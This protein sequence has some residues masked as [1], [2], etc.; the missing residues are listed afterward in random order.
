MNLFEL[1]RKKAPDIVLLAAKHGALNIRLFGSVARKQSDD[2][3]D[4]DF[5]IDKGPKETW[6][7]WFPVGLVLDLE[8]LLG[9]KVDVATVAMLKP[10][11]KNQILLEAIPLCEVRNRD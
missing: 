2:K 8:E 1:V 10:E 6:S 7:P 3:S 9:K 4:I 5:L 11:F